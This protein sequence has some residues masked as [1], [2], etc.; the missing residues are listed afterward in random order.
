[1]PNCCPLGDPDPPTKSD[2]QL[3]KSG[4]KSLQLPCF[5][6]WHVIVFTIAMIHNMAHMKNEDQSCTINSVNDE[7]DGS[8]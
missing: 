4:F 6:I 5:T 7:K 3:S 2:P 8:E 1:M